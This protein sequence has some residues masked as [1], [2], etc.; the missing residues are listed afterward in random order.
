MEKVK[1]CLRAPPCP[2]SEAALLMAQAA[3]WS[4]D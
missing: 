3:L 1:K 2:F 4:Q